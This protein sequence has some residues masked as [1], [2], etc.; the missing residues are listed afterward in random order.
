MALPASALATA[1]P[2]TITSAFTPT[3]IAVGGT[4]TLA[5]TITNPNTSSLSGVSLTDTLPAGLVVD[6]PNGESGTCGSTATPGVVTANSGSGTISLTGGSL[7]GGA[8][9]VVS[10]NVTSSAPGVFQNSTGPVSATGTANGNSDTESLTV[11][12]A[13]TIS[14]NIPRN[15]AKFNF[16]QKV[17]AKFTCEEAANGPG[18]SSCFGT[19]DDSSANLSSGS[20]V[21]TSVAGSHTFTV[22]AISDDGEVTTD[23]VSYAV[24]PDN[25]F[26]VSHVQATTSGQVSFRVKVPGRGKINVLESVRGVA[27]FAQK[28]LTRSGAGSFHVNV[29]P[30]SRGA[31][32]LAADPDGVV[33]RLV[34][35]YTPK[36][37]VARKVVVAGIRV[38]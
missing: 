10:V 32:A 23:T 34:V 1:S 38:A 8:N 17:I 14:L 33:I 2:P 19:V 35:K 26:K 31:A 13:P 5:F 21:T 30:D 22:T 12:G 9:C 3:L 25:R 37:G 11:V 4:S 16:D 15:N 20:R 27:K 18:L 6:N 29:S 28:T 36:G 24:R 7:K